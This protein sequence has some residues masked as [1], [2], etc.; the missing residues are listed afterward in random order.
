MVGV[1]FPSGEEEA[2]FTA[3]LDGKIHCWDD[4]DAS[5]RYS[6]KEKNSEPSCLL[7]ME[8]CNYVVTGH[9]DGSVKFW[10]P[11]SMKCRVERGHTNT[12]TALVT[13]TVNRRP[14]VVSASYDGTIS[15]YVIPAT[16][17]ALPWLNT[18]LSPPDSS[19]P[20]VRAER[21][22]TSERDG[23]VSSSDVTYVGL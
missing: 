8:S 3:G 12:V 11:D 22:A 16:R 13:A 9:D 18:T 19:L 15:A 6:L 4:Y 17:T 14:A 5:L 2:V 7:Y 21:A 20:E 10:N 23:Y 1:A